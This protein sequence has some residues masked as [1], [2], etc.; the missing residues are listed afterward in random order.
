M[1]LSLIPHPIDTA[2]QRAMGSE[3]G[4]SLKAKWIQVGK[5]LQ[6]IRLDDAGRATTR[7]L[8]DPVG[9]LPILTAEKISPYQW[10][11]VV[12]VKNAHID[13]DFNFSEFLVCDENKEGIAI[14]GHPTQA[15]YAVTAVLDNALLAINLVAGA[16]PADRLDVIHQN[17][18]LKLMMSRELATMDL[19]IG[20]MTLVQMQ[21]YNQQ[22]TKEREQA[23][24]EQARIVQVDTTLAE[25]RALIDQHKAGQQLFN[26]GAEQSIGRL[27]LTAMQ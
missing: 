25:L 9:Y 24:R 11:M 4:V 5:G 8:A 17:L 7:T 12:D 22:R 23:A 15:L 10:Q 3:P 18:P 14:Y 13:T 16:F 6:T 27:S 2:L 26:I 1:S 20:R 19:A 21:A